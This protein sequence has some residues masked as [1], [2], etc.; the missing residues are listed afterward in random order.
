VA[1]SKERGGMGGQR[2]DERA[3]GLYVIKWVYF[4]VA[5]YLQYSRRW[6]YTHEIKDT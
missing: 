6:V 4:T 1:L 5:V 3:R 2:R